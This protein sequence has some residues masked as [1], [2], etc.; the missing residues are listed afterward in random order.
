M[1]EMQNW[2]LTADLT[3][4]IPFLGC[5]CTEGRDTCPHVRIAAPDRTHGLA[6]LFPILNI[7]LHID[8]YVSSLLSQVQEAVFGSELSRHQGLP[9]HCCR[10]AKFPIS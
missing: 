2:V 1:L 3:V 7:T 4:S 6:V 8:C 10:K 5:L 9:K